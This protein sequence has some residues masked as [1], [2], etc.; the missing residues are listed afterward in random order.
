MAIEIGTAYFTLL[1][2]MAGTAA[3]VTTGLGASAVTGAFTRGGTAGGAAM[4]AGVAGGLTKTLPLIGGV[5]AAVGI[6]DFFG[7]ATDAASNLNE[8][9]NAVKVSFGDAAE[10]VARLGTTAASRLGLSQ[11][12]FNTLAVR[13]SSFS[14]TIAGDTRTV[15]EV[16][17]ELT[18]RGADFAS[19]YNLEVADALQLFQSGLAGESE[20]LRK[21]G[22]DVSAATISATAYRL[23]IADV[24]TELT[25]QQKIQARYAAILEQTSKVEGDRANTADELANQSRENAAK[26]EDALARIGTALLPAATA[27]ANF[28]GSEKNQELLEKMVDLFIKAE[29]AITAAAE[30][31]L[32]LAD[33]GVGVLTFFLDLIDALDDGKL[34]IEEIDGLLGLLPERTRQAVA[35]I[36]N[37]VAGLVNPVIDAV[38]GIAD[39]AENVINSINRALGNGATINFATISRIGTLSF[40]PS[41]PTRAGAGSLYVNTRMADGGDVTGAGWSWVGERGPELAFMPTGAQVQPLDGGGPGLELGPKTLNKLIAA[42]AAGSVIV[43]DSQA[44]A[45]TTRGG[46]ARSA[47]LGET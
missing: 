39:A 36:V 1:P 27:F 46:S 33:E 15:A 14:E 17:D 31:F 4:G 13:F 28:I 19:V 45:R 11:N 18:V 20:P 44:I 25:E 12:D 23:G 29:P 37:F 41:K 3:A 10:E 16:L 34:G 47:A 40:G 9:A 22:I 26:F 30:A 43:A 24:G 5:L 32:L 2:S 8:S 6:A 35:G 7:D 21:F 38:N 42:L